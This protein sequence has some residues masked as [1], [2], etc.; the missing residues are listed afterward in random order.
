MTAKEHNKLV[1]IFLLVHGGVSAL[2]MI[3]MVVIYGI[4]GAGMAASA[5]R[6]EE[7]LIGGVFLGVMVLIAV[8]SVFLIV[9]QIIGGMKILKEKNNARTWGIIG[10]ILALLS[11]PFGTA[12]G[13]YGLWFLFGEAGKG[14]YLD[15]SNDARN[16]FPPPPQ[17]W[18]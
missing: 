5:T 13:V 11:F 3:F 2:M 6:Q 14:F 16:S 10:S 17:S 8:V 12:A 4:I 15:G 18:Q 1:G 7:Q 9:P